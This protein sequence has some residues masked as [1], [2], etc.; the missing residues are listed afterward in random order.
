MPCVRERG[1]QP[2]FSAYLGLGPAANRAVGD[3]Q[4]GLSK[5]IITPAAM[6]EAQ[7]AQGGK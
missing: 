2:H 6:I 5:G 4:T 1:L 3:L 7:K